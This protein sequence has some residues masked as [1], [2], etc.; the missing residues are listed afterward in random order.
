[1]SEN[2]VDFRE[3]LAHRAAHAPRDI[4]E[5]DWRRYE[6][7]MKEIFTAL[8]MEPETSGTRETPERFLRA[9]YDATAGYEGDP[10][11][12]TAFP[13]EGVGGRTACQPGRRRADLVPLPLR[14]PRAAVLRPRA[15]R[16]R[17]AERNHRHLEADTSRAALRAALHRPGAAR[18][19]DR[20]LARRAD[21]PARRR[22]A[23]R[24]GA[25]V[26][27]DA[28]G[29]RGELADGDDVLARHVHERPRCGRTSSRSSAREPARAPHEVEGLPPSTLRRS[30]SRC[31]A[32][33]FGLEPPLLYANF[34]ETSTAS[35]PSAPSR[36]RT[37]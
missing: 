25:P 13:A 4:G 28:R 31:T 23:P 26:H 32:G 2:V 22:V 33:P 35:S 6:R 7:Y 5:A 15:R 16:L 21:R 36:A 18:R 24:G 34:V 9:L 1:V 14:A 10:K 8:G 17:A 27:A 29:T 3:A 11:L 20:R 12:L 19:A 30:S 37:G